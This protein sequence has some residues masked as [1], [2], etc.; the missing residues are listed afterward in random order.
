[1]HAKKKEN[2]FIKHDLGKQH[3][4]DFS[5]NININTIAM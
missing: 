4:Q 3:D 2:I 1:M 5:S